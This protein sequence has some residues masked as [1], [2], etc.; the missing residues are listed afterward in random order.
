MRPRTPEWLLALAFAYQELLP[1]D[2]ATPSASLNV[3]DFGA[4][5]LQGQHDL[6]PL[7]LAFFRAYASSVPLLKHLQGSILGSWLAITQVGFAPTRL[8][9]LT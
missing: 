6:F 2:G 1:A 3:A 7:H 9:G 4:Q 8:S 5:R